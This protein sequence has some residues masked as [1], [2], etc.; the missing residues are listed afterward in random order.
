MCKPCL[1]KANTDRKNADRELHNA[2]R[3]AYLRDDPRI[4]LLSG[5]KTRAKRDSL[6]CSITR[7]DIVIPTHCPA[8]GI[9]LVINDDKVG[10]NSPTLDKIVPSLGYVAGNVVVVSHLA[11]RIKS[12][13][14]SEQLRLVA[15]Y[16]S[17]LSAN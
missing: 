7:E 5:A 1:R 13:A 14:T 2:K 3:K 17:G 16:Y 10:Y 11:N 9:L 15:D 6:P 4:A 8:L 12:N